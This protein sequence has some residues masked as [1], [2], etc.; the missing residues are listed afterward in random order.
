VEASENRFGDERQG[1]PAAIE[2]GEGTMEDDTSL[3]IGWHSEPALISEIAEY[4][5]IEV[6]PRQSFGK[7]QGKAHAVA[8]RSTTSSFEFTGLE[9]GVVEELVL[10]R[11]A[12][13]GHVS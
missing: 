11:L 13:S 4:Y 9:R 1:L 6:G 8:E 2:P 12:P 10:P 5:S 3:D 7:R